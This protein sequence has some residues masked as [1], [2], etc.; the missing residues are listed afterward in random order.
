MWPRTS[1]DRRPRKTGAFVSQ[2]S[3]CQRR[4]RRSEIRKDR[5]DFTQNMHGSLQPVADQ[6]NG[7]AVNI[8]T[9]LE[10]FHEVGRDI[11]IVMHLIKQA[12]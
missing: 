7:E 5:A 6:L 10:M 12:G 2:D 3:G 1:L 9:I 8:L 11:K 4:F